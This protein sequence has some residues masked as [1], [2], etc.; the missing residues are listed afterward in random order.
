MLLK[1]KE[2]YDKSEFNNILETNNFRL[3]EKRGDGEFKVFL[4]F[5][6]GAGRRWQVNVGGMQKLFSIDMFL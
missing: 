1:A 4:R 3:S 2:T 6:L 5:H